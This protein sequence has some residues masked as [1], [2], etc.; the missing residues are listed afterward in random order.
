[1]YKI[2]LKIRKSVKTDLTCTNLIKSDR[3]YEFIE[4][5]R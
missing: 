4:N 3:V 5:I 2:K 1:M